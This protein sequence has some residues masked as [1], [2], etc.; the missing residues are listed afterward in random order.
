MCFF[1]FNFVV[2]EKYEINFYSA[3]HPIKLVS[4]C[5]WAMNGNLT[6]VWGEKKAN[7]FSFWKRGGLSC[8]LFVAIHCFQSKVFSSV[9]EK[10]NIYIFLEVE[11]LIQV[12]TLLKTLNV[13]TLI[14]RLSN[15]N[16]AILHPQIKDSNTRPW[17][18]VVSIYNSYTRWHFMCF[19]S[20]FSFGFGLIMCRI[21]HLHIHKSWHDQHVDTWMK[22][23]F[24]WVTIL[25]ILE[26][27]LLMSTQFLQMSPQFAMHYMSSQFLLLPSWFATH[28]IYIYIYNK[29]INIFNM[30]LMSIYIDR[31]LNLLSKN[32]KYKKE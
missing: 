13:C 8:N 19:M 27:V 12:G 10:G 31:K 9:A 18:K 4:C 15:H 17:D 24:L 28:Y 30:F 32:Q 25:N 16:L 5:A 23:D 3:L 11:S 29:N 20:K 21:M 14:L 2:L 22:F 6:C 1:G 26:R 7:I